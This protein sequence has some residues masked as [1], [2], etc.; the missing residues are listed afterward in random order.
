MAEENFS[1]SLIEDFLYVLKIPDNCQ[2]VEVDDAL[3]ERQREE[4]KY[5]LVGKFITDRPLDMSAAK[6]TMLKA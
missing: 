4:Y 5:C 3:L 1:Q 2:V 6:Q